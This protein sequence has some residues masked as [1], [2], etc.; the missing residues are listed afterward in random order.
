MLTRENMKGLYVLVITPMDDKLRVDY[1][2]HREN[3]RKLIELGVDGIIING[4]VGEFH[5]C[6]EQ[7]REKLTEILVEQGK[8]KIMCLT[9]CSSINTADTI[10]M[11]KKA[12]ELGVD[13]VMNVVPY[14]YPPT[15]AECIQYFK[16]LA[17]AC[18]DIGIIIYNHQGITN[19]HLTDD[20]YVA[21]MNIPNLVGCKVLSSDV[22]E[23]MNCIR[24][25]APMK[26]FPLETLWG[27]SNAL[28]GSGVMASFIYSCPKYM[29][30]WWNTIKTGDMQT[31]IKM[32]Y[33]VNELLREVVL[34][35]I[36]AGASDTA[37]TKAFIKAVG[38]W[39]CGKTREPYFPVAQE[40]IDKQRRQLEEKYPQFL[41]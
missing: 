13:G 29:M 32:Q 9:G 16:D 36:L 34:P 11:T 41:E 28:G 27:M 35:P 2:G 38:H 30:R 19:V 8:G 5:T 26:H 40:A 3:I 21:L 25:T 20:D 31:A 1:E 22:Y 39:K 7:E 23:Y 10:R 14:Y 15:K 12:A 6:T 17:G 4:T 24:R 37:G 18:P 33:E